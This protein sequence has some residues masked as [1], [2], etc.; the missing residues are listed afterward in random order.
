[1][2]ALFALLAL[3]ASYFFLRF[4]R[5]IF[6]P[7]ERMNLTMDAVASGNAAARVGETGSRDEIG[8]LARHFDGL[9]DTLQTK[10]DELE[11]LNADL[12]RKVADRTARLEVAQK[13]LLMSEKLAA[14]GQLTAGVAHEINNPIAVIQ[15]NLDLAR[16]VL[17]DRAAPVASELRLADEQVNRIRLIVAK[18]LQF[19]RPGEYADIWRTW[20]S[21]RRPP[22]RSCWCGICWRGAGS[23]W[24]NRC[25]PREKCALPRA[26]CSRCS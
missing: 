24:S 12:D 9:L 15:G 8:E 5:T 6:A 18:L 26:S 22:T 10:T 19:A 16:E 11:R 1:M 14:I 3:A 25:A 17:G 21:A 2:A 13:Q 20:I 4:A 7:L 23:K